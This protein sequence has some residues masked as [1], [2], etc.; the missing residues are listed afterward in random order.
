MDSGPVS[1]RAFLAGGAGLA[2]ATLA[3]RPATALVATKAATKAAKKPVSP[4]VL[5]SDLYASPEPQRFVFATA[6]GARYASVGPAQ[7]AFAAPGERQGTVLDTDL[8]KQGLPRGRGI[9]VV[10]AT[11]PVAGIWKAVAVVQG[12][13]VPFVVKVK[14]TA[15]APR[16]GAVAPRAAS[17]TRADPL[18]VNPICTRRPACPLHDV[19][20]ADVLGTGTPVA[21]MF[22]TPALCQSQYCGPVLDELL[23]VMGPYRDRVTMVHVEIYASTRGA[24][25]APTVQAWG[26]PSEPWLYTVDGAGTILDRLDGAFATNEVT[27][28]L[29]RLVA[30]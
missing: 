13:Q 18:G 11:F 3:A 23:E 5:S 1:R 24:T 9:Y 29:D 19:S 22:A 4:L 17:P 20:L 2:L 26:L 16:P 28:A 6:R 10:D 8:Y 25:T 15:E 21:V 27:A 30:T 12:R 14:E 7:V